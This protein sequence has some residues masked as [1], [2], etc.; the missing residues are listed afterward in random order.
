MVT[1]KQN[2]GIKAV[3]DILETF[4]GEVRD[5]PALTDSDQVSKDSHQRLAHAY[6]GIKIIL[7]L[8][9]HLVSNKSVLEAPQT[10]ILQTRDR[11]P[12]R[13]DLF[14]SHQFLVEL[15]ASILPVVRNMWDAA[16][17]EKAS[18][19][20]VKS[21]I[22]ILGIV[23]K[24]DNEG[25]AFTRKELERKGKLSNTISWR[26]MA[27]DENHIRQIT[28]MG[29]NRDEAIT[30][31]LR[32]NGNVNNA[33]EWL[34]SH[35]RTPLRGSQLS[36][37]SSRLTA[38]SHSTDD[39][40]TDVDVVREEPVFESRSEGT[41]EG[42]PSPEPVMPPPE[43]PA[44]AINSSPSTGIDGVIAMGIDE[45]RVQATPSPLVVQANPSTGGLPP[46][47]LEKGKA[48]EGEKVEP[49][50]V[51]VDD[52]EDLRSTVRENLINRSLDVLQVHPN[53]TF[54][55][56]TLLTNAFGKAS[57]SSDVRKEV[58]NTI[59]QSLVSLNS[60]DDFRPHAKKISSTAHLLGL[61]LQNQD[62]F[63]A[64][65]EDLKEQIPVL[66][67]FIKMHPGEP[68]SWIAN[69]LIVV[70]KVLSESAQPRRVT[71]TPPG[72]Q[73][74][75]DVAELSSY[76][77]SDEDQYALF[78]AVMGIVPDIPKDDILPLAV[79][80]V[81]VLLTRKRELAIQ[82]T[83]NG[84]LQRLFHML[85][86]QAGLRTERI[87][88]SIMLILRHIIEDTGVLTAIMKNEI[89]NWFQ[90]R[91]SRQID[92]LSFIRHNHHLVL[93]NPDVF[94]E[95]V[96]ELCKLTRYDSSLRS[97]LIALKET[98]RPKPDPESKPE[99]KLE[100]ELEPTKS[101]EADQARDAEGKEM[102]DKPKTTTEVKPPG[103]DHPD[104]VI[105]FLLTELLGCKDGEDNLSTPK[106]AKEG[107]VT[108][109]TDVRM[110][111]EGSVA[112]AAETPQ[113]ITPAKSEKPEF[114][115]EQHP[116]FI[117]R[118]FILQALT[119]LL[120]CYTRTKIEFINFSRKAPPREAITPSKPRSAILNYLLNDVIPLGT[121][122]H[123][124]D[125]AYKKRAT[126]S[127][128]AI[129]SIVSLSAQTGESTCAENESTLL[130]VRKFILESALKVFKDAS[131]SM[132]SLDTKYSR[133]MS[134]TDLFFRMLSARPN[135]NH[136]PNSALSEKS[137]LQIA[138]IMFEKN[139]IA[140]LT[141]SL[142]DIDLNFPSARRVIKYILR[143]LKLLSKTAT[144]LSEIAN[145][146]TPGA[147]DEDEI[148]TA[149]SISDIEDMREETPDLYRNS[150]LGMFEGGEMVDDE[151]SS[152]DED[153]EDDEIYDDEMELEEEMEEE[154]GSEI[155]D[156]DDEDRREGMDVGAPVSFYAYRPN[157]DMSQVEIVVEA[158]Q[159]LDSEDDDD[160]DDGVDED[161]DDDDDEDD[162]DDDGDDG[163][164]LS[165]D[166]GPNGVQMLDDM[167]QDRQG[168]Y[169]SGGEGDWQSEG[170]EGEGGHA[171]DIIAENPLATIAR[172]AGGS[173]E[174]PDP[175]Y[176][177]RDDGFIDDD[178]EEDDEDED[179]DDMD[180]EGVMIQ[181]DYEDD[182]G[183]FS[184]VPWG[185]ADEAGEATR[186]ARAHPRGAG[187]WYTLGG[188]SREPP[189]FGKTPSS[190]TPV[191][192]FNI[193]ISQCRT[194]LAITWVALPPGPLRMSTKIRFYSKI[195]A[196]NKRAH[197]PPTIIV[198]NF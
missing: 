39:E 197:G 100:S 111:Q 9:T 101:T 105:H 110:D 180:E 187:G 1:F 6:G 37:S 138:R 150:T 63:D 83:E 48:K 38:D 181:E 12:E 67:E 126:T 177:D 170:S 2:N 17:I 10:Q 97:Q 109:P 93:R 125:I 143:P 186:M 136:S 66:V 56:S 85:R 145:I 36:A 18:C 78:K 35:G 164:G 190:S 50:I 133:M 189:V 140:A 72:G 80:R 87:Q 157:V 171:D 163:D 60:D 178:A 194:A 28:D 103:L 154:D 95:V 161:E 57:E 54:E 99:L 59:L 112:E 88:A 11:Q 169:G 108:V 44:L 23:L 124:E 32:C 167:A 40:G 159:E 64:C 183:A 174:A 156:E 162:E 4:W 176:E 142:A 166:M 172:V 86:R 77:I 13:P 19:S 92:T 148:S 90:S 74:S 81:L 122:I 196:M 147:T 42:V 45:L 127:Q 58:A 168:P 175:G 131:S 34:T 137:Q 53:V 26:T 3:T 185:W 106:P 102:V 123:T 139:F 22:E 46:A 29:F 30:A 70:E 114:K 79:V 152:Y 132:E 52:L 75:G 188:P 116:I 5:L 96:N 179:D 115:A 113:A 91:G 62:F 130:F 146:S 76:S 121:L 27:P 195:L 21:V 31:L 165:E 65:L 182:E 128:W 129:L 84:D 24:A 68:A 15:R 193:R 141:S 82:M 118:C 98:E 158:E 153:E 33:I 71:F 104:G 184:A 8:F 198:K 191:K 155:S 135:H 117:Y 144:D 41:V 89:R 120:S 149:S 173:V 43:P 25:G 94:I 73:E 69:I 134:L 55:L 16:S 61:V 192:C 20:I 14:N 51:T 49:P 107:G 7:S 47:T 160:N 119:E 151:Q